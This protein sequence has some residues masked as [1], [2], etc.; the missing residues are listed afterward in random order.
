MSIA[1]NHQN[2]SE[3]KNKVID[4][5]VSINDI[6]GSLFTFDDSI[7]DDKLINKASS[8][9]NLNE[10]STQHNKRYDFTDLVTKVV[11]NFESE[12]SK[13]VMRRPSGQFE[14]CKLYFHYYRSN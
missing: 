8:Q 11:D 5:K 9:N 14:Q 7:C 3:P 1:F 12:I 13:K 2:E 4:R 10:N 6:N